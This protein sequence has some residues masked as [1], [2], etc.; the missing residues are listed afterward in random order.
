MFTFEKEQCQAIY[1]ELKR[2]LGAVT[3]LNRTIIKEA[4]RN[5]SC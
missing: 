5:F 2:K 1:L 3:N 4:G